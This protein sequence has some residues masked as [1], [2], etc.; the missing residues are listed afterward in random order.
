MSSASNSNALHRIL[1]IFANFLPPFLPFSLPASLPLP[2]FLPPL[3][4]FRKC[5]LKTRFPDTGR[6]FGIE[7][8]RAQVTN[9][10]LPPSP[11]PALPSLPSPPPFLP[12]FVKGLLK[13][14]FPALEGM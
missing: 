8:P 11:S 2:S 1:C 4:K 3:P 7:K 5:L 14:R 12:K 9:S 13:T 6:Y 10:F